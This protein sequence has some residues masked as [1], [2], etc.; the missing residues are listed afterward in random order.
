[1][2]Q[3]FDEFVTHEIEVTLL[4]QRCPN[5]EILANR[6]FLQLNI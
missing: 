3:S 1:M 4:R 5:C 2:H 6:H